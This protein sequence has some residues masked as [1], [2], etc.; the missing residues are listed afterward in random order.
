M[1]SVVI[2]GGGICGCSMLYELSRYQINVVL[3]EKENDVSVGTT[4]ANSAIIHAGYDP[5]PNTKMAKYNVEGNKII[6]ELCEHLDVLYQQVGSLVI[7]LTDAQKESLQKLYEQG[8]E[9]GVPDIKLLTAKETIALEPHL[10]PEV[11]GALFAPTAGI[12]SP[13]NLAIAL[14]ETAVN[15]GA[16]V[17]LNT[18]VLSIQKTNDCFRIETTKGLFQAD[19]VIN[20]A[21]VHADE[22]NDM[23]DKHAFTISPSRGE[24]HLL[25]KNQGDLVSH[26]IFQCPDH[27]GKGVLVAPTVDGNL[28]VGPNAMA[29]T[30]DDLCTT[31]IGLE[32]VKNAAFKSVPS[33]NF[34]ESIRNFSGL[35]ALTGEE[36]FIIGESKTQAGFFN[37]A[38]MKSPG[39]SSAPA[40]ARDLVQM[41][42]QSGLELINKEHF[43]DRR[44]IVRFQYLSHE[45]RAKIIKQNPLYGTI[46]CRCETVTEGEIVDALHRPIPP[47][48][49]DGVKRRCTSGTGRCQGGFC[50][51]RVQQ[52]IARELNIPLNQIP[53]DRLGMDI[54]TGT[55]KGE[56]H[57]V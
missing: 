27:N 23:A 9:N 7:A 55:T 35:R 14:A 57:D 34:R 53:L 22:I 47:T 12:V 37:F 51:S 4:K 43:I 21:G 3:L 40:I 25:D 49:I 39:L 28:I 2:I 33:I 48:S 15:N 38:G 20:A 10:N 44:S 42:H 24:Y 26:I 30:K 41:L 56:R 46:V 5:L 31:A 54:I 50:G 45:E 18:K 36:D 29:T 32:Y 6:K 17:E 19:Y 13:W 8:I 16:N 52:I 11:K 1:K